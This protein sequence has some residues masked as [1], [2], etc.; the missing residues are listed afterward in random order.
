MKKKI[1]FILEIFSIL[2]IELATNRFLNILSHYNNKNILLKDTEDSEDINENIL[3]EI[4]E[5]IGNLFSNL[6]SLS[7][8]NA[9]QTNIYPGYPEIIEDAIKCNESY[10]IFNDDFHRKEKLYYLLLLYY[11]SSKSK[12]DLGSYTDCTKSQTVYYKN[13]NL[14]E[15]EKEKFQNNS[16]YIIIQLNEKKNCSFADLKYLENEYFIGL[17]LKKGCSEKVFKKFFVELNKEITFFENVS[18]KDIDIYDLDSN[19]INSKIYIFCLIPFFILFIIFL[20]SCFKCTPNI[21]FGWMSPRRHNEMKECFNSKN[22]HEEIFGNFQDNENIVSND[23]G[24]SIVKGLR[25]LNMIAVLIST[26]FFY[27][28]HLPTKIYNKDI[29]QQFIKSPWFAVVCYGSRFGVKILYAMSGF[30]LVYKMLNYLDNCIETKEKIFNLRDEPDDLNKDYNIINEIN[31]NNDDKGDNIIKNNKKKEYKDMIFLKEKKENDNKLMEEEEEE[32]EGEVEREEGKG[33]NEEKNEI[34]QKPVKR[35]KKKDSNNIQNLDK[36]DLANEDEVLKAESIKKELY[37]KYHKDLERNILFIFIIKQWHRYAMFIL[38]IFFFKYG[39]IQPFL[40]FFSPNPMWLIHIRLI[41][42]KFTLLHIISNIFCFSPFSYSTYNQ[43]DPFGMAYNEIIFF[44]IGSILIFYS[45][46]YCLRLDLIT[47]FLSIIFFLIKIGVGIY[48]LYFYKNDKNYNFEDTGSNHGFYPLMFFQYNEDNLRI[49]SFLFSN[50]FFNLPCFLIGIFFGEM[51]YCIQNF[52]KSKERN[53]NFL[54]LPKKIL[55]FY[56]KIKKKKI[57]W[58]ILYFSLFV[59]CVLTYMIC[60][61]IAGV[62]DPKNFF[63]NAKYNLI[64][65]FDT[66]LGVVFYFLCIMLLLLLGDNILVN[67]LRHKYWGIFSRTYWIFLLSFHICTCFIFYLSENRIKLIFYNIIFF[68]I[69]I[70]MLLMI[71]VSFLYICVEIPF[72]KINKIFIKNKDDL[73][74]SKNK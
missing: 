67:Y 64:G 59:L 16:T 38:A 70:L 53:K 54:F 43:N 73:L 63:L 24:L 50:Q 18:Y 46:K 58:F 68:S 56:H 60:I 11:D 37:K 30:E 65:L 39:V 49:K 10:S 33:K 29:F 5:N 21:V 57:L 36:I 23:T 8:Y 32:E 2:N 42:N 41:S 45:Y 13:L 40:L 61:K 15:D 47:I 34:L 44:I 9:S 25:G 19:K 28:Y 6:I 71:I 1:L 74:F 51:N 66:D 26:S 52:A 72:K 12:N 4:L 48:F 17:C 7:L 27:I 14:T 3:D 31:D 35:N 22:N 62:E 55:N 69:E 20:F